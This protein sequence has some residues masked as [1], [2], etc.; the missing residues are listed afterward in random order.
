MFERETKSD[1]LMGCIGQHMLIVPLPLAD[2]MYR[3]NYYLFWHCLTLFSI[4]ETFEI[5]SVFTWEIELRIERSRKSKFHSGLKLV[6][7]SCTDHYN[8]SAIH[9]TMW[10]KFPI[11]KAI[12]IWAMINTSMDFIGSIILE[13][14]LDPSSHD[15]EP[16]FHSRSIRNEK[17]NKL[18]PEGK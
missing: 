16:T 8:F 2:F 13:W 14:N 6:P 1:S 11:L 10:I 9:S 12:F 15:S 17:W 3:L 7:D 18:N 5:Q 4:T